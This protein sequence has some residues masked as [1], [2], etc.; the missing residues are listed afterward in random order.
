VEPRISVVTLGVGD[1]EQALAFYRDGMGLHSTG[2]VASEFAG[3]EKNAAGAIAIFQ[4]EGGLMLTLYPRAELAKDAN[5][6]LG[7]PGSGDF[8]LAQLVPTRDEVDAILAQAERAGAVV[9]EQPR[10]RPWGIYSGYFRDP[11]GHLWELI[12][13][14]RYGAR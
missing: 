11:D 9:T 6:E 3:D 1:L 10:D 5:V 7:A 2:V 14:P 4:L 12:W 13:N 8:S